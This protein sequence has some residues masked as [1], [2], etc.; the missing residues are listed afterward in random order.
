MDVAQPVG[1]RIS[2]VDFR[3]LSP[4]DVRKI[5]VKQIVNPQVFDS[6]GHPISGGLYD[7]A[8]GAVLRHP[9]ATCRLDERFCPGHSGHIELPIALYNPMFFNQMFILL[10]SMCVYCHQFRLAM[11][12]VHRFA[13]KLELL[14]HGLLFDAEELDRITI[15]DGD[16]D[17]DEAMEDNAFLGGMGA[18]FQ[19]IGPMIER[20]NAFVKSCI[21]KATKVDPDHTS[22]PETAAIAESRKQLIK[23]FMKLILTRSK[24]N[25]CGMFSPT[26]RKDGFSKIFELPLSPKQLSN[27]RARG[28]ERENVLFDKTSELGATDPSRLLKK[29]ADGPRYVFSN[30]VYQHLSRLFQREHKILSLVFRSPDN[31]E[32]SS[33]MF[34]VDVI[35]V[36]PNRF[37][38]P[39]KMGDAIHEHVQNEVLTR[40]LNICLRI[41]ELNEQMSDQTLLDANRKADTKARLELFGQLMNTFVNL[42]VAV[43]SFIDSSKNPSATAVTAPGVRQILEKKEGLFRKNMMGKRVNYA[44]RSVISPDPNIETNEIG[45]PPVF[46]VKLTYPEPVTV[47]NFQELRQAVI[48]GPNTWPGATHVQKENGSLVSLAMLNTEQRTALANQLLTPTEGHSFVG[49]KVYRHIRN[50][51]VVIMNRQPTLHKASM[52]GHL[53]RVLPGE[54]TLRLHY[55]NTGAYNADFDGDEMN[56]HFPQNENA[57]IEAMTLA[58]TDSQYITPTSG[59]PLRGL[60]QDHISAGVWLTSKDTFFTREEY[61]QL[62]YGSLRPEDGHT[63]TGRIITLP[64]AIIKPKPMWTGKQVFSTILLNIQPLDRPGLNLKSKCRV[65]GEYWSE[66]SEENTVLFKNGRLLVGVLDKSQFGAADKG[67]VHSIFEIYGPA[68]AGKLLS[69]LGRL[70]TKFLQSHA[71]TCGMDDLYLNAQGESDR[72]TILRDS[73]DVGLKAAAEVAGLEDNKTLTNDDPELKHRLTEIYQDDNKLALLDMVV[74]SKVNAVTSKIVSTCIPKGV[75]K[76]F[77]KNSM[78]AMALSGAKGSNVNVSQIMCC[79]GQQALEGRRVPVMI[80]GKTLPSFQPY[81]TRARAGGYISGRFFSGIRPQE[82]YFHCMAGREGL[83]D[84]AVKTSRSG[85]LQRCLIKPLEGVAAQYDN[86]VRNSDGTLIQFLYGGDAIDPVKESHLTDFKFCADNFHS[87]LQKHQPKNSFD[88]LDTDEAVSYAKKV[89]KSL[90]KQGKVPHYEEDTKYDPAI[91]KYNPGVYL[92]AVSEAFQEKLEQFIKENENTLFAKRKDENGK[93]IKSGLTA[94]KFRALMQLKY[95][96]SIVEPGEALGIIASQS[97]GE[98]STQMTLNTFHFAGH[99]AANVTLGIPRMREIVMTASTNIKTPQM[100]LPIRSDVGDK[101]IEGFARSINRVKLSEF[102]DKITMSEKIVVR[103]DGRAYRN[104][105]V[106]IEFFD[107]E[108]YVN[109]YDIDSD[110]LSEVLL[111]KFQHTIA[112]KV[113]MELKR[114][115]KMMEGN[116]DDAAPEIGVSARAADA[117]ENDKSKPAAASAD[118]DDDDD[119]KADLSDADDNADEDA[120]SAKRSGQ[121]KESSTYDDGDEDEQRIR[122]QNRDS[123]DDLDVSE[124]EDSDSE[125]EETK[126]VTDEPDFA[127]MNAYDNVT[128]IDFKFDK[129]KGTLCTF[130]MEYSSKYGKILMLNILEDV[131]RDVVVREIP[132]IGRCVKPALNPG[133]KPTLV[134]EGVNFAAMWE[135]DDFIDV[136]GI[137]SNDIFSVLQTYGVE[138]ARNTIINEISGVFGR[139]A[140]AVNPRHLELI[141]DTM[142]RE[143]SYLPFNRQGIESLTSPFLKMSFETT[144]NFLQRAVLNGESDRLDSPSA[145]LV[146][147]TPCKVGT[148]SFDI[149]TPA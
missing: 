99:G 140:I 21:A 143:G 124:T 3:F 13:C 87:L 116:A 46:A 90:A 107:K 122:D 28:I 71:F 26:Y 18:A 101:V 120:T 112:K 98:P 89:R 51:D 56:M 65:K 81:E 20:R 66:S 25:N 49:K 60:I 15:E 144:C 97:V 118:D 29:A 113:N 43:N 134:T 142:T 94:K 67:L 31:R 77:P 138:A 127:N 117:I 149:F 132:R 96:Q 52:M 19:N 12:E 68:A 148:G 88:R 17:G 61:Q 100:I 8:L 85:Y 84:T 14:A 139:Y 115:E 59:K 10:R 23:D 72:K 128:I 69:I 86:T 104:Y 83:I 70:L 48:N 54:K 38:P 123:D 27:N 7:L 5:S 73:Q 2:K 9:C 130:Q 11:P 76:H 102:V 35:S 74:Q 106:M 44:A 129:A 147:G 42:Q 114:I 103:R 32:P 34:F 108:E 47:Y 4:E 105:E 39:S 75:Y 6:L 16:E 121:T 133:E 63:T 109:E 79:L 92:G 64:P 145:A 91:L 22:Q 55:A 45:I 53:V 125:A 37:R 135:E 62:I 82:Y 36:P 50:H 141:A 33:S 119:D 58:N 78:Q 57:R 40:I 30:E 146:T 80:S 41:K 1:S 93:T 111:K 24:C 95:M 126:K 137:L 131:C 110:K 136:N